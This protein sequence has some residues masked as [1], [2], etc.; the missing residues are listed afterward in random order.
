[1]QSERIIPPKQCDI[2]GCQLAATSTFYLPLMIGGERIDLCERHT[3]LRGQEGD[4]A[5]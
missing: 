1:M 4:R 3:Y 5:E 2:R